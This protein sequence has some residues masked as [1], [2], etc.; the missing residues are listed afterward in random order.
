MSS[1]APGTRVDE[2]ADDIFR[3]S[4][5]VA[6]DFG[7]FTFNRFLVR[8]D[9]SLLFHSGPR[10]LADATMGAI[11]SLID[12]SRLRH[13]SFSHVEADECGAM[14]ALF[15]VA[16]HAAPACSAIG[17]LVSVADLADRPPRGL[18]DGETIELGTRRLRFIATPHLPHGWDS[19][20][21]FEETTGTLLCGDLF[22]Q[23]GDPPP[24]VETDVLDSSE[25]FRKQMDY[26]SNHADAARR[27]EAL[28]ALRPRTLATMHGS[29]YRGDGGAMLSSLASALRAEG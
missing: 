7:G 27:I 13:V 10:Q 16:P 11:A 19:G 6:T 20:L 24:I 14:N 5:V 15:A 2:I 26:F 28:A 23:P 29:S 12:W 1:L 17:A 9:E 18:A 22:T 8:G 21:L 4:T 25:A 3:I